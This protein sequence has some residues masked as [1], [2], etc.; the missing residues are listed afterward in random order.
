MSISHT[1]YL[2]K[3]F[4]TKSISIMEHVSMLPSIGLVQLVS[5]PN[6]PLHNRNGKFLI[7]GVDN[8]ERVGVPKMEGFV[9]Y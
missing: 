2:F 8:W 3:G 9:S 5:R 4:N 6:Q 7:N 1:K